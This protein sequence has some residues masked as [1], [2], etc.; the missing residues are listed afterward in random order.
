MQ[1]DREKTEKK[2]LDAVSRII[3]AKDFDALGINAV[4]DEAGVAK[5]LIYRYFSDMDGLLKAWALQTH[6][7]T[8]LLKTE[9]SDFSGMSLEKVREKACEIL[10]GQIDSMM[11][12]PLLRKII[13]WHLS[14][15]HPVSAEIMAAVESEGYRLM[16][17]FKKRCPVDIDLDAMIS[18]MIGG[19]YYLSLIS[20]QAAVFNGISLNEGSGRIKAGISRWVDLLFRDISFIEEEK[21]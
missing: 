20:D 10:T 11:E 6:Y 12:N 9:E 19:I 14:S 15:G 7:W 2:I 17:S 21:Q 13:R 3:T 16:E 18:L 4:A 8:G 5:V 1:K